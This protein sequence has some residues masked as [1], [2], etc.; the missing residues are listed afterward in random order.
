MKKKRKVKNKL[1]DRKTRN[2]LMRLLERGRCTHEL[3]GLLREIELIEL[4]DPDFKDDAEKHDI[5]L[6]SLG[7]KW[8]IAKL[9]GE[10]FRVDD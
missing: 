4:F 6:I 2:Q 9:K 8:A 5:S 1:A 3:E 7:V 10:D